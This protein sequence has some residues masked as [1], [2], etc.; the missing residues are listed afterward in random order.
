MGRKL[1]MDIQQ[2]NK[3]SASNKLTWA[4]DAC[5]EELKIEQS[6]YDGSGVHAFLKSLHLIKGN[7]VRKL[8]LNSFDSN[9]A[10][11][12][13]LWNFQQIEKLM[14]SFG[15]FENLNLIVLQK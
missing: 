2:F 14:L 15:D 8:T 10:V 6:S 13:I 3:L 4:H 9:G 11:L 12:G 5:L 7:N 1:T